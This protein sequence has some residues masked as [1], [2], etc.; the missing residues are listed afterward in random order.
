MFSDPVDK[1]VRTLIAEDEEIISLGLRYTLREMPEVVLVGEVRDGKAAVEKAIGM[2]VDL[3][4][5]DISLPLM[6]GIQATKLIKE[7]TEAKVVVITSH[8]DS[9]DVAAAMTAGADAYC[10]KGVTTAQL[11]KVIRSIIPGGVWL[12]SL[13]ASSLRSKQASE[14]RSTAE[15]VNELPNK[16]SKREREVLQLLADGLTN[17]EI[18][19]RLFLGPET[20][21]THIRHLMEKLG[22]TDRTQAA[23][24]AALSGWLTQ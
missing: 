7:A 5:M 19:D 9:Q 16:L 13:A 4:L 20:V 24:K 15:N 8:R 3:V 18:A 14:K 2:A 11:I 22:A 6:D 12:D 1:P 23:V 17:Q 21:K 10:I